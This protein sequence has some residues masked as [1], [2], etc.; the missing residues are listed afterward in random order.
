[1]RSSGV[2]FQSVDGVNVWIN[3]EFVVMVTPLFEGN[4]AVVNQTMLHIM[5][6]TFLVK[7]GLDEVAAKLWGGVTL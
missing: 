3:P 4:T 5:G 7:G 1:M 6:A 2:E